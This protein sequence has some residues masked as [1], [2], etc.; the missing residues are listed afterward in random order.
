M[1]NKSTIATGIIFTVLI[2]MS[3]LAGLLTYVNRTA[4]LAKTDGNVANHNVI[5]YKNDG[6]FCV[7]PIS[8]IINSNYEVNIDELIK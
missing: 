4:R 5:F 3:V 6:S 7:I 1:N 8:E 2:T